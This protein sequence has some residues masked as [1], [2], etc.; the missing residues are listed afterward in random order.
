MVCRVGGNRFGVSSSGAP[1]PQHTGLDLNGGD[2]WV[3]AA[4]N[5]RVTYS[6]YLDQKSSFAGEIWSSGNQVI[7]K[8]EFPDGTP[9]CTGYGHGANLLVGDG[10]VRAGD[11]LFLMGNTGLS[12][13]IHVHFFIRI[14]GS[15]DY[16]SGGYFIDPVPFLP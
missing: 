11:V 7:I 15:G 4:H 9:F 14:G 8:S 2:G 12:Y 1:F 3:R 16:C 10:Q 6:A 5:G 13:G